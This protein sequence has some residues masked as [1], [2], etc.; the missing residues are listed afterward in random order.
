MKST[1][2]TSPSSSP[3]FNKRQA[4]IL[5]HPTSLPGGIGHG[6]LGKEAYRFVD[7]LHGAGFSIWQTLPLGPIGSYNNPYSSPSVNGGNVRLISLE[8]LV[9]RGWLKMPKR[10]EGGA[11]KDG[12]FTPEAFAYH[13]RCLVEARA[14]FLKRATDEEQDDYQAFLA[15]Q[16]YW[17]EDYAS[18]SAIRETHD[19]APWWEWPK[20]L[21]DRESVAMKEVQAELADAIEQIRFEQFLFFDQWFALKGYAN[22]QGIRFFGDMP[23][24]VDLNNASVWAHRH[25]FRL[26]KQGRPTVVTGV[27]PDYFSETGQL[28]GNPHYDWDRM[29][30]DAFLWW[31]DRFR[32]HLQ[33]FNLLRVDHFR[34]FEACWEVPGKDETAM[35]G[36][37]VKA[38][39]EEVFT[40]MR[41][42]FPELPLVAED[43]GVITPEV[44][45]LRDDFGFP[46]MKVLHFGFDGV[47]D[48]PHVPYHHVP[49]SIVYAGTHDNDT[50]L[51]W[52]GTLSDTDR[53]RVY[54]YLRLSSDISGSDFVAAIVR[55]ALAS[56]SNLAVLTM[57]DVLALDPRNRLDSGARMNYPGIAAG[58]W[59]W[60]FSWKQVPNGINDELQALLKLYGR[61]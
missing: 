55:A 21:R 58:N 54:D 35:N 1:S 7:F 19:G 53:E 56:V 8:V 16:A 25:Y 22:Q 33:L 60:R 36:R 27:P 34:G 12:S 40:V 11:S 18:F 14:E 41:E 47:P 24:F 37:W 43:L 45:A 30:E 46:G 28:W 59:Q 39:G 13:K 44:D 26:D 20:P 10:E 29:R 61:A 17:L 4:G 5:L 42:A 9:K 49:N 48:N 2:N 57:Q 38:P 23:I 32:G 15:E 31:R 52:L 6:D 51:G 50:T 3:T